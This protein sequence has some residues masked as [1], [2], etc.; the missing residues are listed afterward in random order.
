MQIA[1]R[2]GI[3]FVATLAGFEI[4]NIVIYMKLGSQYGLTGLILLILMILLTTYLRQTILMVNNSTKEGLIG[5]IR[6]NNVSAHLFYYS[7]IITD[8]FA[9]YASLIGVSVILTL[10]YRAHWL[11][12]SLT[13]LSLVWLITV[14]PKTITHKVLQVLSY[15]S[16]LLLIYIV[17]FTA[18]INTIFREPKLG[19][20]VEYFDLLAL[21]GALATPYT[22]VLKSIN[23][24]NDYLSIYV[25]CLSSILM[26]LAVVSIGTAYL[27]PVREFTISGFLKPI[28]LLGE[29]FL[30]VYVFGLAVI[31]FMTTTSILV[32][33]R[34]LNKELFRKSE[35]HTAVKFYLIIVGLLLTYMIECFISK[36][37]RQ[38]RLYIT[39]IVSSSAMIGVFF[40][41][42]L[43]VIAW[44]CYMLYK[45][46]KARIYL[47][48]MIY[49]TLMTLFSSILS[50]LGLLDAFCW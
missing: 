32:S 48:N 36:T 24:K 12:Y 39:I 45:M 28:L 3:G 27:Y 47:V 8:I 25:G 26:G 42:T 40:T 43:I 17:L 35:E 31:A 44:V 13:L 22:I 1:K 34:F 41:A 10:T 21:W 30:G 14:K 16:L 6:R 15:F 23:E 9:L 50:T 5:L 29:S 37:I 18:N 38:E 19:V 20:H 7:I 49:L 46:Y 33:I 4:K 11:Y 2:I